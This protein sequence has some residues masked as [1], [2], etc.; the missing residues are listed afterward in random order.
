MNYIFWTLL[1]A[2]C[3]FV[4]M[5]ISSP[6]GRK[7]KTIKQEQD[8]MLRH[9]WSLKLRLLDLTYPETMSSSIR[10]FISKLMKAVPDPMALSLMTNFSRMEIEDD[11]IRHLKFYC[12]EFEKTAHPV[13]SRFTVE[14]LG[15]IVAWKEES[16]SKD[17]TLSLPRE[18]RLDQDKDRKNAIRRYTRIWDKFFLLHYQKYF[19]NR[20]VKVILDYGVLQ[21][22]NRSCPYDF[23]TIPY[24]H[25]PDMRI[26]QY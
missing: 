6:S 9:K 11:L 3:M 10:A 18:T 20:N 2:S 8:I 12:S 24:T 7:P 1:L 17:E 19:E 23:F 5:F 26:F 4:L 16:L 22:W 25:C 13:L 15:H 14:E 21:L